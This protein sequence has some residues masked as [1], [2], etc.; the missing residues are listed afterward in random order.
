MAETVWEPTDSVSVV[1][2]AVP[3]VQDYRPDSG[4]AVRLDVLAVDLELH[5]SGGCAATVRRS[6]SGR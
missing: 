2:A 4:R 5:R 6:D 3:P 1:M